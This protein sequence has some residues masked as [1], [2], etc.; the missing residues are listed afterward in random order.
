MNDW[1]I[2]SFFKSASS[3]LVASD[4]FRES[5]RFGALSSLSLLS[6]SSVDFESK[7]TTDVDIFCVYRGRGREEMND[8]KKANNCF[9]RKLFLARV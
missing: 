3:V 2:F 9:L 5:F 1:N 8:D 7:G 4:F 6:L